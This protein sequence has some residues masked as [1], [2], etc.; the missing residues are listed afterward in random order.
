MLLGRTSQLSSRIRVGGRS[1]QSL[2]KI[3]GRDRLGR[4][5]GGS[6][7]RFLNGSAGEIAKPSTLQG[8]SLS[9][10]SASSPSEESELIN[11]PTS[12]GLHVQPDYSY[13]DADITIQSSDGISFKVHSLIIR[14]AS[15][16]FEKVVMDPV[17]SL[18][19]ED[20]VI[21]R[22]LLDSI[23]PRRHLPKLSPFSFVSHLAAAAVKY[24]IVDVTTRIREL[25]SH[26]PV[27]HSG[28]ALQHYALAS[29]Y[30]WESEARYVS[31]F[32]PPPN[33]ENHEQRPILESLDVKSL[34]K[35]TNLHRRRQDM[36]LKAFAVS[37]ANQ[38]AA[39]E[40]LRW[41]EIS[42]QHVENCRSRAHDNTAWAAFKLLTLTE[43][44][45]HSPVEFSRRLKNGF[46]ENDH[47]KI[48]WN[49]MC[50]KCAKPFFDKASFVQE[51]NRIVDRLPGE[52][53]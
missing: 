50:S 35:L 36:L 7:L 6:L 30:G 19:E 21:V 53:E 29:Q 39:E 10:F 18:L 20:R 11:S 46:W 9:A 51:F 41:K 27:S 48:I 31:Q 33:S 28:T 49:D 25:L 4:R 34:L 45:K 8:Q 40:H 43:I 26:E 1:T 24:D 52:I 23:Y 2:L 22:A 17:K 44:D 16:V 37:D 12:S 13:P 15:T 32:V 42:K 3:S 38:K 47:T 5:L 14:L